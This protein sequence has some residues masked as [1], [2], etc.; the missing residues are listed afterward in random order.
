MCSWVRVIEVGKGVQGIG[1]FSGGFCLLYPRFIVSSV[2]LL[3]LFVGVMGS[4][5]VHGSCRGGWS[6]CLEVCLL[7]FW[8]MSL[9]LYSRRCAHGVQYGG[10]MALPLYVLQCAALGGC[11]WWFPSV[12]ALWCSQYLG[13]EHF[14]WEG[15]CV[16][17]VASV[18]YS[19]IC[20]F[21]G[22]GMVGVGLW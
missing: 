10:L 7:H 4:R 12:L 20:A 14:T 6:A 21:G 2:Y 19:C 17:S 13:G 22:R 8:S 16:G 18:L 5:I 3:D 15:H 9:T 1:H 11:L